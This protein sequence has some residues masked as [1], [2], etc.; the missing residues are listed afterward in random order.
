MRNTNCR[1]LSYDC[2]EVVA[3]CH[4][5][6]ATCCLLAGYTFEAASYAL[7]QPNIHSNLG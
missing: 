6:Y 2:H 7:N 4:I 5:G 3:L 1:N